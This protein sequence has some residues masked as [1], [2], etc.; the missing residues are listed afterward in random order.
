MPPNDFVQSAS[1]RKLF[2]GEK[3]FCHPV[4]ASISVILSFIARC[5]NSLV[6]FAHMHVGC[7]F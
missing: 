4:E 1:R 5:M 6:S 7:R 3:F 2:F